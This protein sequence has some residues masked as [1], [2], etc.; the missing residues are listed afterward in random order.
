MLHP[1]R[2]VGDDCCVDTCCSY[3]DPY[4]P[5][6]ETPF[7]GTGHQMPDTI[8]QQSDYISDSHF[9]TFPPKLLIFIFSSL[10]GSVFSLDQ[11]ALEIKTNFFSL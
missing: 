10:K 2:F 5:D 6:V 9:S 3:C 8:T 11:I 1:F 7:Y 4:L